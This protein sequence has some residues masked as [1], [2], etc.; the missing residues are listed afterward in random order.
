MIPFYKC[1]YRIQLVFS[2]ILP[3]IRQ[4]GDMVP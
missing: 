2:C 4:A 3:F 1:P